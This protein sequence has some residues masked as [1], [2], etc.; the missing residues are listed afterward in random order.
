MSKLQERLWRVKAEKGHGSKSRSVRQTVTTL[1]ASALVTTILTTEASSQDMKELRRQ[2]AF[3]P[4]QI[5]FNNDG[6][7]VFAKNKDASIE[8]FLAARTTPLVGSQVDTVAYSTT[9]SFAYF[10]HNTEVCEVHTRKEGL[11]ANNITA[12]LIARGTDPLEVM[13]KF[14]REND[15]EIFW[16][17]RM[18]D[19]H[20]TAD[21]LLRPRWKTDHPEYLMGTKDHPPR[22]GG[23]T[24]VNYGRK[25]VREMAFAV[26]KDVCQRYDVDGIEL[27]FFRHPLFFKSQILGRDA[28]EEDCQLMT[29]LMRRVREATEEIG[30]K[31]GRPILVS[32]RVPDSVEGASVMGM[33]IGRWMDEGLIDILAVSG[34][35]RLNDW[36]TTVALGKKHNVPVFAGLSES[37][38]RDDPGGVRRSIET[39]RARAM[40]AWDAGVD[41]VYLF[42]LFSPRAPHWRELGEPEKLALLDKVYVGNV[43][44]TRQPRS[45]I[46][47]ANRFINRK[48]TLCP[49]SPTKLTPGKPAVG[50]IRVGEDIAKNERGGQKADVTLRLRLLGA[51]DP[52]DY[53][54]KLNDAVLTDAKKTAPKSSAGKLIETAKDKEPVPNEWLEFQ[55]SPQ[56]VKRGFNRIE[57]TLGK[58]VKGKPQSWKDIQL[59]VRY[60][61]P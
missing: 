16:S 36:E 5:I 58:D 37:R 29:D 43:R 19:T 14:C 42:N 53:G 48:T 35:F 4:R 7:D 56:T 39:Y 32:V 38:M 46:P 10:S 3:R 18:N 15:M 60:K 23:W 11:L 6:D 50:W 52:G 26:I 57:V 8:T 30:L 59:P 61:K 17:M 12:A 33:D 27:D 34:Y 44:G 21:P 49:E 22:K 9:R 45:W 51:T 28:T 40:N 55:V 1:L 54:V 2:A 41:S 20:D 47:Q 13:V 25:E 24:R 31:R